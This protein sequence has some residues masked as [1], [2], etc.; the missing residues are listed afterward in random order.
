MFY[1]VASEMNHNQNTI[2]VQT[3]SIFIW[4]GDGTPNCTPHG[5]PGGTLDGTRNCTPDGTPD[6]TPNCTPNCTVELNH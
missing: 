2:V 5:T 4:N 6:G 1:V 3:K